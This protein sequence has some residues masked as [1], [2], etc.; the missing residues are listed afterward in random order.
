MRGVLR[1][2][3][4]VSSS[5]TSTRIARRA[6]SRE[7]GL[8]GDQ[9]RRRADPDRQVGRCQLARLRGL[10][11]LQGCR[12]SRSAWARSRAVSA[13][14]CTWP[15]L[16]SAPVATCPAARRADQRSRRRHAAGARGRAPR[17]RRL[18]SRDLP[19]PLVPRPHR[20]PH[21]RIRG[22]LSCGVVR[23]QL[24]GLREGP[25]E[26]VWART[27]TSRIGSSIEGSMLEA[28]PLRPPARVERSEAG[29]SPRPHG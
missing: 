18:C 8:G 11:Q 22:R 27:R 15:R 4:T 6:R 7:D 1:L 17:V 24:R 10:L 23:G 20:D 3:E 19:R 21:P 25:Q 12:I 13:I 2:G 14:A 28:P 26:A 29:W 5:P 9:R 16:L